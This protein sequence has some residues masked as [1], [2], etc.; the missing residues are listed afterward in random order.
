[1]KRKNLIENDNVVPCFP[2]FF[3]RTCYVCKMDFRLERG[4]HVRRDI[5]FGLRNRNETLVNVCRSCAPT[6]KI[7]Y[8]KAHELPPESDM[9]LVKPPKK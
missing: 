3:W 6:K 9:P 7:A 8:E 1:M 4:W 5:K 2:V